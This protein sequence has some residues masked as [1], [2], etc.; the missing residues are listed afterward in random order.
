MKRFN[1]LG[2]IKR[3][4]YLSILPFS[5]FILIVYDMVDTYSRNY[6]GAHL[7]LIRILMVW[8]AVCWLVVY[9]KIFVQVFEWLTLCLVGLFH[10][11]T[12]FDS[13]YN[14]MVQGQFNPF[15]VETIWVP[16]VILFVFL[17]LTARSGLIVSLFLFL[18]NL[19][20][21]LLFLSK[22]TY[23]D[24][25]SVFQYLVAYLIYILIFYLANYVFRVFVE[26]ES[27]KQSAHYD[28]LTGIANRLQI[29]KWL[30]RQFTQIKEEGFSLSVVFFDIDHFKH[31]N[32]TFGHKTGDEVLKELARFV[33]KELP[34]EALFGRWGGEEFIVLTQQSLEAAK[35]LA[36]SLRKKIEDHEFY[37]TGKQTVSFG[38]TE[39][40]EVDTPD[41][42]LNRV[43]EALYTSKQ[44]GRNRVTIL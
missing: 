37:A 14:G 8:L 7:V 9:K 3:L 5:L 22:M 30:E 31:I 15:G 23:H 17:T 12:V 41:S 27:V 26:L 39:Y 1:S 42:L 32:D 20:I 33:K 43:D 25:L 2:E 4:V 35:R 16:L 38:V 21:A 24:K 13:I 34:K 18:L 44:N 19:A 10:I 28:Y 29:D 40:K 36:E 11:I 6:S